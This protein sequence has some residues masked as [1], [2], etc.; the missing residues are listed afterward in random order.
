MLVDLLIY[1]LVFV[2][3][4]VWC[5]VTSYRLGGCAML[6]W[7]LAL[8]G[9]A[10]MVFMRDYPFFPQALLRAA[11]IPFIY[12]LGYQTG[13]TFMRLTMPRYSMDRE[14]AIREMIGA[15]LWLG[16]AIVLITVLLIFLS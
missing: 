8:I 15:T 14:F 16:L 12:G 6:A 7:P 5:I 13:Y 9:L 11:L 2:I 4:F 3:G 1:V 10:V